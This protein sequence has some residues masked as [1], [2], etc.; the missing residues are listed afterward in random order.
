[1]ISKKNK[2]LVAGILTAAMSATAVVP[3]FASAAPAPNEYAKE[4]DAYKSY[5]SMFESLYDDV[6]T[7][8]QKNG[9][10]SQNTN[11]GD[12]FGIP[13]H[14]VETLVIEA[15]DYGH[16]TTSEAMSYIAWIT[17]MHDVLAEKGII[18]GT[19]GDLAKGW[20]TL[21]AM[22]PGWSKN[23]YGA[24]TIKYETIF[25]QDK[26]KADTTTEEND[27]SKYPA[28]KNN[29]DGLN[30]LYD[31]MKS[32]YK[33]DKGYYMMHWLADVENWYG[34][35]SGKTFTFINTFQR[36]EQ[37]SCFETVPHGCI[38]ELKY[39]MDYNGGQG[40]YTKTGI[41]AVFNGWQNDGDVSPQY[42]FTNAPDAED[43]AIQAI[44]FGNQFGLAGAKDLSDEAGKMGD[45]C[46][47]DMFDKYYK[48]IG[49]QDIGSSS[50]GFESQHF[51]MAWYT[52]WGGSTLPWYSTTGY[53]WAYQIGC[54]HSHQFYQNPLAAYALAFDP[55][56]SKGMASGSKAVEDYKE[57]FKR[58]IEMYLWLQS[59]NGPYAGGCTN[60]K[61]GK[62]E[63]YGSDPTF[64]NMSY[65]EHPVYADPGSNHWIGNQVW[66]TQRL[67]ELYYYVKTKNS[68]VAMTGDATGGMT[69]GGLSLEEALETILSNWID[70]F[71]GEVKW[72]VTDKDGN[73][74]DYAI[75]ANLDWS[76][77]PGT[78][79]ATTDYKSYDNSGLT[80][81]VRDYGQGDIGCVSSLCNTLILYAAANET[82]AA[83]AQS[84]D[85]TT[86]GEKALRT[87][88]KLMSA[89]WN[90]GRDDIGIAYEGSNGSYDRI[91]KQVVFIPDGFEGEMPDGS[92]LL[93]GDRSTFSSI[94]EKYAEDPMYQAC[95]KVYE[96]TGATDD[97][98]F[99]VHRFWHMGDALMTTGMMAL[100]YPEVTPDG[101]EPQ[102]EGD[103]LWGDAN[104]DKKVDLQDAVA[105]L[106]YVALA[107]KY[108]L[109]AQ[110]LKN[111]DVV[112]NGTS[113]VNAQDALAIQ[114]AD[115]KLIDKTKD[116]PMSADAMMAKMK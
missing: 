6:I 66:S 87:A 54:S 11:G 7:N 98:K 72:N 56:I 18:N 31:Q 102:T 101:E 35:G 41:K 110:G 116:W 62:Y 49:C 57:S 14:S 28:K 15:P 33:G 80:C 94:R 81:K 64:Y 93:D 59:A 21:E 115:A 38:E 30:P 25:D 61:N 63:K 19:S 60:S 99:T 69:F 5:A 10:L 91:F 71:L 95:K 58:Q 84:D 37:E 111:A 3:A 50:A 82:P 78:W 40:N 4:N 92:K 20:K 109:G 90:L 105:I 9:Y 52:A 24:S 34:F 75:P 46:R 1:M 45:Q 83:A 112:D 13:Y 27:P 67:A 73:T 114:M 70:W 96:E 16:E 36:G 88:N 48:A 51:L 53:D 8:G 89:Q 65:V 76:G 26:L 39:G 17:A 79:D 108:P 68:D 2:A 106:Q 32:A 22:I 100:L 44:F 113:G 107:N 43:R 12:S 97:Y 85:G 42:G 77:Q 103:I 86:R 29:V 47:N 74:M 55:N 104:E 23:A